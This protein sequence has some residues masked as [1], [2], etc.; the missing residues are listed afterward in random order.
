MTTAY[1]TWKH[2][3][4]DI[5][6]SDRGLR[7]REERRACNQKIQGCAA[8]VLHVVETDIYEREFLERYDSDFLLPVYDEIVLDVPLNDNL[9]ALIA[10][11]AEIMDITPPGHAIPM[12]AEFSFGPNWYNQF[13]LGE[14]PCEKQVEEALSALF[15]PKETKHAA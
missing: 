3:S 8:D 4:E 14:R 5:L 2:L 15:T 1:G 9:P 12:M 13:E 7:S 6:S 11:C 10:E